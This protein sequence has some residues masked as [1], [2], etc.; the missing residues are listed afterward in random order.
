[1]ELARSG[2]VLEPGWGKS[3]ASWPL[4]V[5]VAMEAARLYHHGRSGKILPEDLS[6][7]VWALVQISKNGGRCRTGSPH[8]QL[9]AMLEQKAKMMNTK[10]IEQLEETSHPPRMGRDG[11]AYG[12]QPETPDPTRK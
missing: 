4:L 10:R 8:A 12:R 1:L 5:H 7:G 9:E 11:T 6:R 2:Q 3:K